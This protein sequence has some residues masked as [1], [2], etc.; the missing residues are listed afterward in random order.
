LMLRQLRK[1]LDV[2]TTDVGTIMLLG[3]LQFIVICVAVA[4]VIYWGLKKRAHVVTEE[5]AWPHE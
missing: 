5:Q 4:L 1:M 3:A 2:I